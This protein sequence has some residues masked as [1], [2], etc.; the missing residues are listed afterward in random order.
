MYKVGD[1]ELI[2]QYRNGNEEAFTQLLNKYK[3]KVYTTIYLIV[4]DRY[5][6]EDLTQET[7][8]KA[9]KKITSNSYEDQGKFG[10][11][12]GT[13][14]HN[15]AI[16]HFRKSKRNPEI[17]LE[18]GSNLFNSMDFSEDSFESIQIEKDTHSKLKSL[19]EELPENQK[20]VIIMRHY[21]GMSFKDIAETTGVS[22][23]T[24]LGRM[25]YGLIN[26]RKRLSEKPLNAYDQNYYP[27]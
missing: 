13:I 24:A 25:R 4:N 2:A 3:S 6:A 15:M 9:I 11:W 8:I 18:D 22:I 17:T 12:I 27:K 19:L 7:F 1:S 26:L 14:A 23:N 21:A 16:D 5:T 10:G 20:E